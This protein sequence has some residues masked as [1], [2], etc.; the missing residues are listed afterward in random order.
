M[1]LQTSKDMIFT[2]S[3]LKIHAYMNKKSR[4]DTIHLSF[5]VQQKPKDPLFSQDVVRFLIQITKYIYI[6]LLY[7]A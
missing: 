6:Y 3:I 5:I 7:Q 2:S 1:E 4:Y